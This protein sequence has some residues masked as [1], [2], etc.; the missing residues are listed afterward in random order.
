MMP[1]KRT[2]D[3]SHRKILISIIIKSLAHNDIVGSKHKDKGKN[4]TEDKKMDYNTKG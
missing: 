3:M 2:Y 1:K 4:K